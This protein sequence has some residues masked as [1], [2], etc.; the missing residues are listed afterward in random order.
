MAAKI[1]INYRRGDDP[2][3]A[4]RLCDQLREAFGTNQV[5]MDAQDIAPGDDFVKVLTDQVSS[6]DVLLVVIGKTWTKAKDADGERRLDNP[7]DF[8]RI[9][10]EAALR[11]G[12]RVVPVLVNRAEMPT[13]EQLPESLRALVRRN[14]VRLTHER[15]NSDVQGLIS[16]LPVDAKTAPEHQYPFPSAPAKQPPAFFFLKDEV[17]ANF[18]YPGEQEYQF[19]PASP[20]TA[21]RAAYIRLFPQSVQ[22]QPGLSKLM[23]LFQSRKIASMSRTIGGLVAR[24][25]YGPIIIDAEGAHKIS[26]LTQ[27]F[28]SGESLGR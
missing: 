17:L 18:G 4:G 24:N 10:I 22:R 13:A 14:A 19:G 7:Q 16:D 20:I 5:F 1:F 28:P 6:C 8:V 25:Q 27:G 26:G 21:G 11:L 2:G 9:E 12:K 3:Y 23:E 15:F